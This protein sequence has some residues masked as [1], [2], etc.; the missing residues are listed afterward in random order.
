MV[1]YHMPWSQTEPLGMWFSLHHLP[2]VSNGV[3]DVKARR[4]ASPCSPRTGHVSPGWSDEVSSDPAALLSSG[5]G[6]AS[7]PAQLD[8]RSAAGT[9]KNGLTTSQESA[10]FSELKKSGNSWLY[11]VVYVVVDQNEQ[12]GGQWKSL[13]S[14]E[15]F[16][17]TSSMK[18]CPLT[19]Y[20]KECIHKRK[21]RKLESQTEI[22]IT[23]MV[24]WK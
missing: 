7:T 22:N 23:G 12:K 20:R 16:M 14:M 11:D 15:L 24:Q 9:V 19:C 3:G 6:W 4:R 5:T 8:I 13:N 17:G 2:A 21:R 18:D 1:T 10:F